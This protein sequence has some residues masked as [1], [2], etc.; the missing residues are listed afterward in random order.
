MTKTFTVG[1]G[2]YIGNDNKV[3]QRSVDDAARVGGGIVE[4]PVG[5]Y[6]MHNALHLRDNVQIVG[7]AGAVLRKV[8]SVQSTLNQV[9]GYG[10]YEFSVSEPELFEIGMGVLLSDD[11]AFGF[12]T[13]AGTI[14]DR[15]GDYFYLDRPFAHDYRPNANAII[16]SVFSLI[17]GFGVR[18]CSVQNLVLD[19][20]YPKETREM[21]GCRG[22]GIFL[23]QTHEVTLDGIEVRN[24]H[25]DAISFQQSIDTV[26]KNCNLHHN[27]G[28]GIHPG[29]GSVRY[30][31]QQNQIHENGVCGIYYCLR[32][33]H[34]LC[35]EN[36]IAGNEAQGISIGERDTDHIIRNNTIENNG[37]AGIEL[38]DTTEQ[39]ADRCWIEGNDLKANNQSGKSAEIVIA[40]DLIDIAITENKIETTG[41]AFVI[42]A[43]NSNLCIFENEV[44][45]RPQNADDFSGESKRAQFSKPESF[46]NIGPEATIETSVRHL[47]IEPL[48][49]ISP[50]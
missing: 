15:I 41:A 49:P 29:S 18:N 44:N 9:G 8:P 17:E 35:E 40:H 37:G 6:Q 27:S 50:K 33:T 32:T 47:N 30:W 46:P 3:L 42:G 31:I 48:K 5:G 10:H 11:N 21:N 25:G 26:V 23:L 1:Q 28:G 12:Y 34:S 4:I 24:F 45:Y 22:A 16:T 19:G 2:E 20:N 43:N 39:S 38:R 7:E 13:T 14:V 36:V